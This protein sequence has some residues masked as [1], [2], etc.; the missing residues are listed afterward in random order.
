MLVDPWYY[1]RG[2]FNQREPLGLT[3]RTLPGI[4]AILITDDGGH[5]LDPRTLATLAH[6][7]VPVVV[8]HGLAAPIAAAG[9][10]DVIELDRWETTHIGAIEVVA[11][12]SDHATA[13]NG[14]VCS[15]G[16]VTVYVAGDARYFDGLAEIAHRFPRIDVALL[17]IGGLRFFGFRMEMAPDDAARAAALLQPYRVIP[18]H[19][20][21][22]APLPIYWTTRE[23]VAAFRRGLVLA[24]VPERS[25]VVLAPGESWHYYP[26]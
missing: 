3:F 18:T 12:P 16:D 11:V 7:D 1:P 2:V 21:L 8:P 25:L 4:D 24:G 17:P 10:H 5:H 14:Y 22:T 13:D 26:D 6:L 9:Y 15:A 23:P 19:Y 20:G